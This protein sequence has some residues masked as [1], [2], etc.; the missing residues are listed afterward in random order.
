M[1]MTGGT[2]RISMVFRLR[3]RHAGEVD[4]QISVTEE[5]SIHGFATREGINA[6]ALARDSDR[7]GSSARPSGQPGGSVS[8]LGVVFG[9]I[10]T[11]PLYTLKECLHAAGGHEG[12]PRRSVRHPVADVLGADHGGHGQIPD[13]SSCVPTTTAR[14]ASSPCWRSSPSG[15]ARMRPSSGK[16]TGMALLAVIGASLLYGD[17]VITPAISVLSAVEGLAVASPDCSRWWCRSPAPFSSALFAIQRRGTGDIGKLFGPVMA[18]WFA[19]LAALGMYHIIQKPEI[20]AAL[21]PHHAA[22]FFLRHG[23]H[24]MLILGSVVLAVT[25]GE[26][27]YADM[28]HFGVRPIRL[29]WTFFVLP[30]LVLCYLGQGALILPRP[31]GQ[32]RTR[33]SRMVPAGLADLPAGRRCRA[34]PP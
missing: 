22:A 28:G 25:G 9:D 4:S 11:S 16:V 34:P 24:G 15:S 12:Q 27:L 14:A 2:A 18:V 1:T 23:I 6:G 19:T 10:G 13:A 21:S 33:S 29:A 17:G 32:S 30:S 31:R 5:G 26:A 20:L 8:V 3:Q 7:S